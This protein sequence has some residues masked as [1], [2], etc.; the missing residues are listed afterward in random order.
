MKLRIFFV[1]CCL[2]M[3]S[4]VLAQDNS[5]AGQI[6]II[7]QPSADNDAVTVS[8]VA[9]QANGLAIPNVTTGSLTLDEP[10]D[11]ITLETQ[12]RLP[13]ALAII[14]DLSQGSDADLIQNT[15][16][17]YFSSNPAD[18]SS[19]Y[20]RADDQVTLYI[21]DG[22]TDVPREVVVTSSLDVNA[23]IDDLRPSN[24]FYSIVPSFSLSLEKLV[25]L[26]SP[27]LAAQALY[28]GSFLSDRREENAS[29]VFA[30]QGIPLY[31]VQSHRFRSSATR[32]MQSLARAGGGLFAD[33]QDGSSVLAD[34]GFKAVNLVKVIYDTIANGRLVYTLRYRS[35][36]DSFQ[37]TRTV[38]ISLTSSP[39]NT[40]STRF[41]YTRTFINPEITISSDNLNIVRVSSRGDGDVQFNVAEHQLRVR[42]TFPDD[43]QR[44]LQLLRLEVKDSVSDSTYVST[45]VPVGEGL[46]S[47]YLITWSLNAFSV[48]GTVTRVK[49]VVTAVDQ[50]GLTGSA[51]EET[52]IS[53]TSLPPL[54]T[55]IPSL[56]PLPTATAAPADLM[57]A[58]SQADGGASL[59]LLGAAIGL[60]LLLSLIIVVLQ[61]IR[62]R[63]D[64]DAQMRALEDARLSR[65][66]LQQTLQSREQELA[67]TSAKVEAVEAQ[68]RAVE[69]ED[70]RTIYGRLIAVEGLGTIDEI[71]LDNEKFTIGRRL[72]SGCNFAIDVP[73]IS[74]RHCTITHEKGMFSIRDH[75]S[76][77]G[78][79]VNGDRISRERDVI[80]PIGSE[81][82]I[83]KNIKF[84]LWDPFTEV[85]V[86]Q[87]R[88]DSRTGE[89]HVSSAGRKSTQIN[90]SMGDLAFKPLP[91]IAY[92]DDR[93][94]LPDDFSPV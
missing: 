76:K 1:W 33:N 11:D 2:L 84:E 35:R 6:V 81:I 92:A 73:F 65:E 3:M 31:V 13:V 10:A 82:N 52:T 42:V 34:Q 88:A 53:V 68:K 5:G 83:T 43:V 29:S 50:I 18:G 60:L 91:G 4:S 89:S 17:A 23:V 7:D 67:E 19:A 16:R 40:I 94:Q 28:I 27:V 85:N 15:L 20:Y 72:E 71:Q 8:F 51:T 69:T 37:A 49:L 57:A 45:D 86:E 9:R 56:T 80:V 55:P 26:R 79:W 66:E 47:D 59:T 41:E 39:G 54:P 38:L 93:E 24:R 78:V 61:L 36:S 21:L 25:S 46:A 30:S 70:G 74:P 22:S 48:P 77:N 90:T 12:S 63:R 44:P 87:K 75:N 58:F 14:V 32:L 62:T 64:Y